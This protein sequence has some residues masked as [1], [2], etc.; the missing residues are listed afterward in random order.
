M[1]VFTVI[2]YTGSGKTTTIENLIKEF[3]KRGLSVGTV[4]EI[5]FEA[6][7]MDTEG[8]N[9]YRHREAGADTVTALGPN[10]TD[11]LYKGAM[12]IY[13]I[14]KHY[15]QDIVILEGVRNAVVPEIVACSEDKEPEI[16]GLTMALSGS[17]AN[18]HKGNYAGVPI[19]NALTEAARL[20]EL[21][22]QKT[23]PLMYDIDPKCCSECG[24]D[25]RGLL[26]EI[27]KGERSYSDCVLAREK[28]NL[29]INGKSIVMVPFVQN[30]IRNVTLGLISELKGYDAKSEIVL[31][32]KQND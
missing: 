24:T 26:A 17:Y 8:K 6:F 13:D 11:V 19:I 16:S 2:G 3:V 22:L 23:P 25:C 14:L 15:T 1:K 10:E 12:N 20:A 31:T 18:N 28:V 30:I 21:V 7:R 5:H 9:T 4:K 29:Q 32:I 27:L